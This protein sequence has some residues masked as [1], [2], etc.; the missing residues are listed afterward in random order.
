MSKTKD[1]LMS[2]SNAQFAAI[3]REA[4]KQVEQEDKQSSDSEEEE[5][6]WQK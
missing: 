3:K 2:L 4:Q 6:W 1:W 5:Q